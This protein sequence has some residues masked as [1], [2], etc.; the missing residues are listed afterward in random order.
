MATTLAGA[1][2]F[3]LMRMADGGLG[4]G[5]AGQAPAPGATPGF[6]AQMGEGCAT[7]TCSLPAES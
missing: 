5:W 2:F 7:C 3:S 1:F 6:D 4:A